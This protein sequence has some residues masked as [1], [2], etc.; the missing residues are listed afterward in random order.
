MPADGLCGGGVWKA[1][2]RPATWFHAAWGSPRYAWMGAH[3]PGGGESCEAVRAMTLYE[4]GTLLLDSRGSWARANVLVSWL[5]HVQMEG[6]LL[7]PASFFVWCQGRFLGGSRSFMWAPGSSMA[8]HSKLE[9]LMLPL[10]LRHWTSHLSWLVPQTYCVRVASV[11]GTGVQH[12]RCRC[13]NCTYRS[14]KE[15]VWASACE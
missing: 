3:R 13:Q 14:C 4:W 2:S 12:S 15:V 10:W 6:G 9:S 7:S 8:C 5:Q 1:L 11:C